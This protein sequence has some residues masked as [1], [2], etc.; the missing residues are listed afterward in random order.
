MKVYKFTII[1]LF[2]WP[3]LFGF[4]A[5]S[6]ASASKRRR[7]GR[8]SIDS[9]AIQRLRIDIGSTY[10]EDYELAANHFFS[11]LKR[12]EKWTLSRTVE[13]HRYL[14]CIRY[15]PCISCAAWH[16]AGYRNTYTAFP[17]SFLHPP[18]HWPCSFHWLWFQM[19]P[20]T[21][22]HIL[23]CSHV[24]QVFFSSAKACFQSFSLLRRFQKNL[25]H[26]PPP[27]PHP[28]LSIF[29]ADGFRSESETPANSLAALA[30]FFAAEATPGMM[31]WE[32][33]DRNEKICVP[34]FTR[35]NSE[36]YTLAEIDSMFFYFLDLLQTLHRHR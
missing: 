28:P 6:A 2:R 8:S 30:N 21:A 36:S 27:T 22:K 23:S 13:R 12:P 3:N 31:S 16:T 32:S 9:E 20:A 18:D 17:F 14:A 4:M 26:V 24:V 7:P 19:K 10:Y 35:I 11:Q 34:T 15:H 25:G 33:L 29:C 1:L 5:V